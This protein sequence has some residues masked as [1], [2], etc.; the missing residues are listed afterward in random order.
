MMKT[1][2]KIFFCVSEQ[3]SE[4]DKALGIWTSMQEENIEPS[5]TFLRELGEFLLANDREIPFVLPE[6]VVV[7]EK[8]FMP[9]KPE[10]ESQ[11]PAEEN[12]KAKFHKAIIAKNFTEALDLKNQ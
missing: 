8:N 3:H 10:S 5:E 12:L 9:E 2:I 1:D 6:K 7:P 4:C 11:S